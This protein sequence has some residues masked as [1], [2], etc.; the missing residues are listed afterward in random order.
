MTAIEPG[1]FAVGSGPNI[2]ES[3]VLQIRDRQGEPV[4]VGFLITEELALTCAHVVNAALGTPPDIEPAAR[5]RIDVTLP[6]LRAPA[7]PRITASVEH[8]SAWQPSGAGDVEAQRPQR[9]QRRAA[10]AGCRAMA[11]EAVRRDRRLGFHT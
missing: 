11:M 3:A 7:Q 5:V 10:A 9:R 2:L 6:L 1:S 4:G 8:W